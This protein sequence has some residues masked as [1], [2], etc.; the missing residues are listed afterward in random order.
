LIEKKFISGKEEKDKFVAD[1]EEKDL[2]YWVQ[3]SWGSSHNEPSTLHGY[4][5]YW[6]ERSK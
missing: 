4:Y 1:L 3:E 5:V 6:S 2:D